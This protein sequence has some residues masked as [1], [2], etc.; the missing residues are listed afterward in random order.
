MKRELLLKLLILVCLLL[1]AVQIEAGCFP[2]RK[3][4]AKSNTILS[5][6]STKTSPEER[7]EE[8]KNEE[9]DKTITQQAVQMV[10]QGVETST[11]GG[12]NERQQSDAIQILARVLTDITERP[13]PQRRD[14]FAYP[15]LIDF[16]TTPII[17]QAFRAYI[18]GEIFRIKST[19]KLK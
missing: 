5:V 16:S 10:E 9:D 2:K 19:V 3:R 12:E 7:Q 18:L 8:I 17:E 4:K 11:H 1:T 14:Y 15:A 13:R 6:L